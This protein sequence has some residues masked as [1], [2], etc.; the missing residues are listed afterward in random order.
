MISEMIFFIYKSI[1]KPNKSFFNN[2]NKQQK[3]LDCFICCENDVFGTLKVMETTKIYLYHC[4]CSFFNSLA[5][6]R[7]FF[8][9]FLFLFHFHSFFLFRMKIKENEKLFLHNFFLTN[10]FLFVFLLEKGT[11]KLFQVFTLETCQCHKQIIK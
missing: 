10:V 3:P 8:L 9:L 4:F 2:N 5:L 1:K 11:L 7:T 6:L